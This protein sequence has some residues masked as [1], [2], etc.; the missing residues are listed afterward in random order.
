MGG[1]L[2]S[3]LPL[4]VSIGSLYLINS[5]T[6][7]LLKFG[8]YQSRPIAPC[9]LMNSLMS[10]SSVLS[11]VEFM[12]GFCVSGS[13]VPCPVAATGFVPCTHSGLIPNCL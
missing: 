8:T 2:N 9:L 10:S 3:I 12:T 11:T 6:R 5:P 13:V 4:A 1:Q 7:V